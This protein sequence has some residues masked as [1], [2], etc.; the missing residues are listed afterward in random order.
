MSN[1]INKT[2]IVFFIAHFH[3]EFDV[4][5]DL[6]MQGTLVNLCISY[7]CAPVNRVNSVF[8]AISK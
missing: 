8:Y 6:A 4:V 3:D 7:I 5:V 2:E 1:T